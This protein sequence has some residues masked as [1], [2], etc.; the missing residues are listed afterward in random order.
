VNG[1]YQTQAAIDNTPSLPGVEPGDLNFADTNGD[2]ELTAKDRTFIGSPIPDFTYGISLNMSYKGFDVS[3][4]LSGQTGSQIFN[5]KKAVR[6]GIENFESSFMDRWTGPGTSNSEPRIGNPGHNWFTASEWLLE[7]GSFLK[8]RN[9]QVGYTLPQGLSRPLGM[10]KLRIY[11]NGT[12][13]VTFTNY[14]GYTPEISGDS[15]ISDSIDDGIYP[16][17]QSIT[18]G[19]DLTF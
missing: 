16:I 17:P 1:V 11:A 18:F 15:V 2:G 7:D 12:N 3:T 6:F 5:A 13:L 19:I 10:Q 4:T 8:I 9:V 14:S